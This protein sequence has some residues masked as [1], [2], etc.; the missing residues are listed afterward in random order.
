MYTFVTLALDDPIFAANFKSLRVELMKN[1]KN[2]VQGSVSD[3]NLAA[4]FTTV[5]AIR[6]TGLVQKISDVSP[7]LRQE[8]LVAILKYGETRRFIA[9]K[10]QQHLTFKD[11]ERLNLG[12]IDLDHSWTT[13]RIWHFTPTFPC[14]HY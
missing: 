13:R 8:T 2:L 5:I 3:F 9:S 11:R 12:I 6:R 1:G 14:Q 10:P 7:S 4:K